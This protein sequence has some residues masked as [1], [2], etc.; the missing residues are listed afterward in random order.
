M[1]EILIASLSP[2]GHFAPLLNVA[3]GLVGRG[4]RVTVLTARAHAAQIRAAGAHAEPLPVEADL[5]LTRPDL[6]LTERAQTSGIK[7][8]N[9]DITRL[10]LRPM[11]HQ[12]R[13][14]TAV[15][16][17]T[18]FDA[19]ITDAGFFGITPFLLGDPAARPPVL[20]YSTTPLMLT[21][22][23]TAPAGL[24]MAPSASRAGRLRNRTLT[25]LSPACCCASPTTPPTRC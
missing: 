6:D 20:T 8:I 5:D 3:R 7:R 12:T 11:P 15:L 9:H 4:D 25:A 14:L 16:T 1:P 24:G 17:R 23:D 21:S 19:V 18:K 13:A 22:R 2:V 10:F